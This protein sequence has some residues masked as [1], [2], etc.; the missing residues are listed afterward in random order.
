MR[1]EIEKMDPKASIRI[2]LVNIYLD[3]LENDE[4]RSG[5]YL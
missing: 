5:F 3:K 2:K 4:D 1:E